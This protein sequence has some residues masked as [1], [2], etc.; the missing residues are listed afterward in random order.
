MD[1]FSIFFVNRGYLFSL[2]IAAASQT[3]QRLQNF[4]FNEIHVKVQDQVLL[5]NAGQTLEANKNV[6]DYEGIGTA[7]NPV[8]MFD[9][10]FLRQEKDEMS[11]SQDIKQLHHR[12]EEAIEQ[13]QRVE[14]EDD[15]TKLYLDLPDR[16]R[17]CKSAATAAIAVCAKLVQ[18]HTL[19]NNGWT[20]LMSNMDDSVK[21]MRSRATRFQKSR[22]RVFA[23]RDTAAPL[24]EDFD[25]CLEQLKGITIPLTLLTNI[26]RNSEMSLHDWIQSTD[27]NHS[28]EDLV[29]Q[30]K[31]QFKKVDEWDTKRIGNELDKVFEQTRQNDYR[32]IKGINIRLNQLDNSLRKAE[33]FEKRVA[34]AVSQILQT[35][36]NRDMNSLANLMSEHCLSMHKIY[37]Q[38]REL[39]KTCETFYKSKCELLANI[40]QRL[41]GWIVTAYEKLH[42][43]HSEIVVYEEKFL[44]LKQRIDLVTQ[45]K[46]APVIYA[47]AITEIIRRSAFQKEFT[48]WHQLHSDQCDKFSNDE[49]KI[50][51][52]FATKLEKH[53]LRCLFPGMFDELPQFFVPTSKMPKF[54]QKM[55]GIDDG[56]LHEL[57]KNVSSLKAFLYVSVPQVFTRLTI[58]HLSIP[59]SQSQSITQLRRDDSF[60]T[61]FP[62]N[63]IAMLHKQYPSVAW[64]LAAEEGSDMSPRELPAMLARSP[65][66]NFGPGSQSLYRFHAAPSLQNLEECQD[67]DLPAGTPRSMPIQIPGMHMHRAMGDLIHQ[68]S[69]NSS[70]FSTPDDHFDGKEQFPME[71]CTQRSI[72]LE[73]LK[74]VAAELLKIKEDLEMIKG[75][76]ELSRETFEKELSTAMASIVRAVEIERETHENI[77]KGLNEEFE[78][79]KKSNKELEEIKMKQGDEI[80]KQ[81]GKIEEL[82]ESLGKANEKN[83]KL[84]QDAVGHEEALKN[85]QNEVFKRLTIEYELARDDLQRE[86]SRILEE[87]DEK[88]RHVHR[89]LDRKNSEIERLK[90]DPDSDGYR[91]QIKN[92]IKQELEKEYKSRTDRITKSLQQ[93][94]DELIARHKKEVE[95][96]SRKNL[97]DLQHQIKWVTEERNRLK[98]LLSETETNK[99]SLEKITKEIEIAAA[100]DAKELHVSSSYTVLSRTTSG[101]QTET[102]LAINPLSPLQLH[103]L[104]GLGSGLSSSERRGSAPNALLQSTYN[105][106]TSIM[107]QSMM[108]IA[109]FYVDSSHPSQ[110]DFTRVQSPEVPSMQEMNPDETAQTIACQT[111]VLMKNLDMMVTIQDIGDGATVL[112]LWDDKHNAFVIFS[113]SPYLHFVKESSVKK[114]GLAPGGNKKS[115]ILAKVVKVDLCV[116]RKQDNRY[117]LPVEARVYRVEVDPIISESFTSSR[118]RASTTAI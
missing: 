102:P 25:Q 59:I 98:T 71:G 114:L 110:E 19:L 54:D 82:E 29:I 64:S 26:G 36:Q 65:P 41:T 52:D 3:V 39:N 106:S 53:F 88:I 66:S 86:H 6:S 94:Q 10:R 14:R 68:M 83:E 76:M 87:K 11:S 58:T 96:D 70:Q 117:N 63:N 101:T 37:D 92:D 95:F 44:G 89:E 62:V 16:A 17:D 93:K 81:K 51:K 112:V 107:E 85:V 8:Y 79:L 18:E 35:P 77:V 108:P 22:E 113:T 72:T 31:D 67:D 118:S 20:A 100:N 24:L 60:T 111:R 46:E 69:K 116:I 91:T 23:L 99:E 21:K 1:Y 104:A 5:T 27:S 40:K 57:R 61:T 115:W 13:A 2:D 78:A 105:Q 80:E 97:L 12:I 45:V 49:G 75:E 74:P 7:A 4:I 109:Q 32:E 33:E 103:D 84:E 38:L 9:R 55:P 56:Y 30:V 90:S 47:T 42:I 43:A 28:L 15:P 48:I 73:H 34:Q 50:R